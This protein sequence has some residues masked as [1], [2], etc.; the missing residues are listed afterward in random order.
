MGFSVSG[1]AAIVFV[2]LLIAFGT[3]HTATANNFE[4]V[5]DA[6]ADRTDAAV[7]QRNTRVAV[8]AATYDGTAEELTVRVNNTGAAQ[9]RLST[10]DL[11]V[12]GEYVS[13]W[14][15]GATVDGD[16]ATD[17][18][19]SGEQLEVVL[20]RTTQPDRVKLA[21]ESGV[22]DTAEVTAT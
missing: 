10:S 15:S 1:S 17:L 7:E 19:L 18:W 21:T 16:G 12:D 2:G 4:R 8:V 5:S 3:W 6:Q 11:L 13:N 22:A 9:L 20:S 14:Q